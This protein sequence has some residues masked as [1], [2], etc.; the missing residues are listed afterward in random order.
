MGS[1]QSQPAVQALHQ[2]DCAKL[3][4][5]KTLNNDSGRGGPRPGRRGMSQSGH[6]VTRDLQ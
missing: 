5:I 1:G 3:W 2:Q 6:A 4:Q